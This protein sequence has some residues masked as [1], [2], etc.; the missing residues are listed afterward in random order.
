MEGLV[1]FDTNILIDLFSGHE[2]ASQT[3]ARFPEK[4]AISLIT[5]IEVMVGARKYRQEERTREVLD[6][7]TILPVSLTV[8]E[9]SVEIRQQCGMKLPDAIILATAQVYSRTLLTRN[10]KDFG[11]IAGAEIPYVLK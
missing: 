3:L 9:R 1:V 8:A 11:G 2:K 5:W 10:S 6:A 7:F 4:R